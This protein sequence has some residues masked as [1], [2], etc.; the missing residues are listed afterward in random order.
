MYIIERKMKVDGK[1]KMLYHQTLEQRDPKNLAVT[2][3]YVEHMTF[4]KKKALRFYDINE[5]QAMATFLEASGNTKSKIIPLNS[6]ARKILKAKSVKL[7]YIVGEEA[8]K[9]YETGFAELLEYGADPN[10]SIDLRE[11]EFAS[12][13]EKICFI[14]GMFEMGT[15][16][17]SIIFEDEAKRIEEL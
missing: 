8:V 11:Q 1:G 5:V 16:S 9:I 4:N 6:E 10:N 13:Q 7:F 2:N 15:D 17:Y 3:V 12:E 14:R